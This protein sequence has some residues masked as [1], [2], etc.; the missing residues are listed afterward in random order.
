VS[1]RPSFFRRTNLF[2]R[3]FVFAPPLVDCDENDPPPSLSMY[4]CSHTTMVRK[5]SDEQAPYAL[6]IPGFPESVWRWL[7]IWSVT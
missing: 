1:V 4:F 7:R 5:V 2:L 3:G 6:C